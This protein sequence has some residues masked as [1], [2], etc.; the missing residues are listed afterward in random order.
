M[1]T[2]WDQW[3]KS[4]DVVRLMV[5]MDGEFTPTEATAVS[6]LARDIGAHSFW[7]MMT[8]SHS[9][10]MEELSQ[11]VASVERPE[12][13]EWMYGV[14]MGLA[15]VDGIDTSEGELLEWLMEVWEL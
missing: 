9:L 6:N 10:E 11:L 15:A 14:L 8:E 12:V 1:A 13:R 2:G 7:S 5:R 4:V 3:T